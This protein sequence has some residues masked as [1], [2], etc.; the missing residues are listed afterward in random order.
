M[1]IT[2]LLTVWGQVS[3][4]MTEWLPTA[5]VVAIATASLAVVLMGAFVGIL[6]LVG[7]DR[8][9]KEAVCDQSCK[10]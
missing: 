5:I 7:Y 10:G 2:Y 9:K 3:L 1:A 8:I 4:V 6:S